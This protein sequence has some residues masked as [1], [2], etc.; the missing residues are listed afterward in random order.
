MSNGGW[1]A[2]IQSGNADIDLQ[3]LDRHRQS[4]QQQGLVLHSRNLQNGGFEVAAAPNGSPSPFDVP[5][6]NQTLPSNYAAPAM[7]YG[8]PVPVPAPRMVAAPQVGW[9]PQPGAGTSCQV[10]GRDAPVKLVTFMQNIGLLFMRLPKT[11]RGYLCRHCIDKYFFEMTT[12]TFFF[13][14]WGVISF[15]YT[16]IA[17]PTNLYNYFSALGL[18]APPDDL[19]SLDAKKTRSVLMIV[20]GLLVGLFAALWTLV[21]FSLLLS[22]DDDDFSDGVVNLVLALFV[23][24]APAMLLFIAGI[25]KRVRAGKKDAELRAQGAF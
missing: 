6:H 11:V 7:G 20:A 5:P 23:L 15:I 21:A 17:L 9:A 1:K 16:L 24:W 2:T 18:Q 10:C 19:R 22:D 4:A 12:I 13:G 25:V 8:P 3:M 14:W